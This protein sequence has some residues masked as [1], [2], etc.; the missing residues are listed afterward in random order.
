MSLPTVIID[1]IVEYLAEYELLS[2]IDKNTLHYI[3]LSLNPNAIHL[4]ERNPDKIDWEELSGNPAAIHLLER[5]PDKIDWNRLSQNP[6]AIHLLER[7]PDKI[8][9]WLLCKNPSIF[10]LKTDIKLKQLLYQIM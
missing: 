4:L 8:D 10:K 2:W 5:N 7:N 9:W 1:I 3:M 6:A